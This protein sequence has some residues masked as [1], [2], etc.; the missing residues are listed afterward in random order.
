ML[1]HDHKEFRDLIAAVS[2]AMGIDP[3]LVEKDY[4]IMH[5]L[6]G[7]Q[8]QGFAFEL[9]G[10][11]S[12]SKGFGLI[13]RFSEDID[14]R[15]EPPA[16]MDVKTGKNQDKKVHIKSRA[17][18]YDWVASEL[19]ISGIQEVIR[20]HA[21]DD[22][23]KMRS[24]GI[25]LNYLST[26]PLLSG[27]KDGVLLELGFDDTAPNQAVDI[28]SWAYDYAI[29][30]VKGLN[31]NR[32]KDVLCYLPE[33]TFVE[34]LQTITT[35]YRQ[36]KEGKIFPKNFL[37]HYYDLYCLL[38]CPSVLGFFKTDRYQ[39][40]KIERFPKSDNLVISQNPAFL[41]SDSQ[42]RKLFESEYLKVA[43]LYYQGQPSFGDLL[44]RIGQHIH[45]L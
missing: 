21:F 4:W 33:Y 8:Q 45:S 22:Q 5:C 15:I 34:K 3:T 9:K 41:L 32:A 36:Y 31:D 11:T 38:D 20:D 13:H 2:D 40:R 28:S 23:E 18:Y 30:Y 17:D 27:L 42:D 25:R 26:T 35:K 7:V 12:L 29:K 1:L 10:G 43:S 24:G 6:W 14:I 39:T 44:N 16:G 19:K 37:R